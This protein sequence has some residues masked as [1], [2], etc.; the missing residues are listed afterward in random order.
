MKN[1]WNCIHLRFSLFFFLFQYKV[2]LKNRREHILTRRSYVRILNV[3]FI[4]SI[5]LVV[6]LFYALSSLCS[7]KCSDSLIYFIPFSNFFLFFSV[8][9][10]IRLPGIVF[11]NCCFQFSTS[12][13]SF[14]SPFHLFVHFMDDNESVRKY[15][16]ECIH[17]SSSFLISREISIFYFLIMWS[18][19]KKDELIPCL[20]AV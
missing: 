13:S 12:L 7:E 17:L 14:F 6:V 8:L 10:L 2:S 1:W 3:L 9:N 16:P 19:N 18:L 11:D 15:P 20:Y 5:L 4:F